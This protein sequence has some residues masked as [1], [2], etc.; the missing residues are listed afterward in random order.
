MAKLKYS[1]ELVVFEG[2]R[3]TNTVEL[4]FRSYVHQHVLMMHQSFVN[5]ATAGMVSTTGASFTLTLSGGIDAFVLTAPINV[6]TYG[7]VLGSGSTPA[8]I[9]D[10]KLQSQIGHGIG[11]GQLSHAA[12][13]FTAPGSSSTTASF[14]AKRQFTNN[15]GAAIPISEAAIY[16]YGM[17]TSTTAI[18]GSRDVFS[19]PFTLAT[20]STVEVR[21]TFGATL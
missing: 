12:V 19:S 4:P 2:G 18:C 8:T 21:Y 17:G 6:A 3:I 7:I 10:T 20:G 13:T 5:V 1:I 9:N 16:Y 11:V 15:S 14:Q